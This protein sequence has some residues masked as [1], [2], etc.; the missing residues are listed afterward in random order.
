MYTICSRFARCSCVEC[1]TAMLMGPRF[2]WVQDFYG[3]YIAGKRNTS[4]C[5]TGRSNL[6]SARA[7]EGYVGAT[8][9][10]LT[11]GKS[12]PTLPP[13]PGVKERAR[14]FWLLRDSLIN[15]LPSFR[16]VM[17]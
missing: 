11:R 9:P 10:A 1:G 2:L 13:Q 16:E 6:L 14:F 12:P 7:G 4:T 3:A 8:S 15:V 17:W 5:A